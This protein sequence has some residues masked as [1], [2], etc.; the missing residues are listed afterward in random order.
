MKNMHNI[1]YLVID[2]DGTMT[3]SGIFYD[4]HGNEIKR[5][6]T[7][8]G[9]AIKS[10]RYA[11]IKIIVLTGRTCA[12]TVRRMNE[13]KV[14]YFKEGVADKEK[15][16]LE[17]MQDNQIKKEELGYIGD[18]LNDLKAMKLAGFVGCPADSCGEVIEIADYVSIVKGGYGA[19]RDVIMHILQKEKR[20][21]EVID[22]LYRV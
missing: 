19:V 3:D 10:A 7:R 8:D 17:L 5:F 4:D 21:D 12:A 20:W 9:E 18:D 6:S 14:D 22:S 16:L 1:N 2:V 13:L 11:G 15:V